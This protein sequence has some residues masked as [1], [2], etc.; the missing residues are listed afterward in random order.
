MR[1]IDNGGAWY[2]GGSPVQFSWDAT[3]TPTTSRIWLII[4]F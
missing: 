4:S 1:I 3:I 2:A